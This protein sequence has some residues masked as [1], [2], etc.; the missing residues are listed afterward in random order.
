MEIK[1]KDK[2][3]E[4]LRYKISVHGRIELIHLGS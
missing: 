1:G 4:L 2:D 3:N